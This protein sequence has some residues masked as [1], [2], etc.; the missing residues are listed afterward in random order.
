MGGKPKTVVVISSKSDVHA[1]TVLEEFRTMNQPA[2][3]LDLSDFPLHS[4]LSMEYINQC[5]NHFTLKTPTD[6]IDFAEVGSIW[7]RRP[8]N[9]QV[10]PAVK[11]AAAVQFAFNESHEAITGLWH[12]LDVFWMNDPACDGIAQRKAYQLRVARELGLII[13]DTLI[14]SDPVAAREFIQRF[15]KV[16]CKAFSATEANWRETRLVGEEELANLDMVRF[17]PVI[18]QRY[19]EASYDLRITV[20]GSEIFPAAIYSQETEYAV[21][22]RIDIGRARIEAVSIPEQVQTQLFGLM[23]KLGLVYGAID[24]R[25]QPDGTYV[26]LEINPAGQFLFIEGVTKQPMAHAVATTLA[27]GGFRR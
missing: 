6:S 4:S 2:V 22:C 13:P 3:L 25:L 10:D 27:A 1:T 16:I 8:Q 21:D 26:F 7:W 12:A 20:V 19:I 9:F 14:T 17:A 15:G 5:G 24:M 18:F 23:D 11:N